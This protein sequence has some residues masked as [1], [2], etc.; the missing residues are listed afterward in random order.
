MVNTPKYHL[1]HLYISKFINLLKLDTND[2]GE[3]DE[4]QM[5]SGSMMGVKRKRM[6]SVVGPEGFHGR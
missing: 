4:H 2:D 1:K 5:N 6:A 3:V